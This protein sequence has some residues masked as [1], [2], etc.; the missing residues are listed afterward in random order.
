METI[1]YGVPLDGFAKFSRTVAA[2]G[3]VLLKNEKQTLP[4]QK[5]DQLAVF[6]RCQINYYRSGTGSGGAVNVPYSINA[7]DG[8]RQNQTI[9]LNEQLAMTYEQWVITHPFDNGGGGW[10]AEPWFQHE[11]P[12]TDELVSQARM[13][14][15]KALVIIGRTAGEDQD[16][17]NTAGSYQLTQEEQ[18]MLQI[19]TKYFEHVALVLNVSNILDLNFINDPIYQNHISA[20]LFSWQG[21]MEGGHAL[22]DILSANVTPSGKLTTTIAKHL[23][24]YPSH[25]NFGDKTQNIYEEDIYVGYRYFETFNKEAVLYPFGYGLSYT[26]FAIT[27]LTAIVDGENLLVTVEVK[28]TGDTYAGKEVVQLYYTAPQGKLGKPAK[29]LGAYAKTKTLAPSQ[30]ETL[31]L[32]L[33]LHDMASYDDA[34]LTGHKSCYVLEAGD[35]E[36][37]IGTSVRQLT[38]VSI[39]N[40]PTLQIKQLIVTQSLTEAMAPTHAFK[41]FKPMNKKLNDTYELTQEQTPLRTVSLSERIIKNL[42]TTYEFTNNKGYKLT[43]VQA[44]TISLETFIAQLSDIELATLIRGEGM[45]SPKVTPGTAAAFGGVSDRLL[46]YNIP[47]ACAADGPSGIRMDSGH[48]A[49]QIPIGTLLA[50]TFDDALVQELYTYEGQELVSNQIDT[51]LGPGMN[52]HRHPLNGR[53]F[54]YFSEDPYLTG[55]MAAACLLGLRAGGASGTIKH[56]AC[57]DQETARNQTNSIVSERALREIHLKPFEIAVKKGQAVSIMT[58][59]NPI[60]GHWA[61]SNY[62]LNTTILRNEWHYTG[63]VMTDWWAKMNHP[64]NGGESNQAHVGHMVRAQNDLFMV[65]P[66]ALSEV[67]LEENEFMTLLAT[68]DIDTMTL[69]MMRN[70]MTDLTHLTEDEKSFINHLLSNEENIPSIRQ[71]LKAKQRKQDHVLECLTTGELTRGE[72]QRCAMNICRFLMETKAFNRKQSL[73]DEIKQ[74][75]S[76]ST[77]KKEAH[78]IE[79]ELTLNITTD[80]TISF[81]ISTPGI[82]HLFATLCYELDAL[83]QSTFNLTLNQE[84]LGT[85][86]LNGTNGHAIS[87]QL[88]TLQLDEG[89]Y[90]LTITFTKPGI[91]IQSLRFDLN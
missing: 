69:E 71:Y 85:I 87:K 75:K 70:L 16:N 59:Y 37:F 33:P 12:L 48:L 26:S 72:L 8:L 57:N 7:L 76:I 24:D 18:D 80:Q 36:F 88:A 6:G 44:G 46:Q 68:V 21:G 56:F 40:K 58:S 55:T 53:N 35:Y 90:E 15:N 42:P 84:Y 9:Q 77:S 38:S 28:N 22:A 2:D 51:L 64:M 81:C 50:C 4:I 91:E 86:Q 79:T 17:A 82:Y 62:D 47:I 19:V 14:S 49:T 65:V 1:T 5:T 25:Q 29:Q 41:R 34:G 45:C 67:I 83:A 78:S 52:I 61:A 11:M 73:S 23:S 89:I 74:I 20:I 66:D 63:I 54:E 3:I 39:Q 32:A 27:P 10:A 13:T 31:T 60:N 30:T 43:D